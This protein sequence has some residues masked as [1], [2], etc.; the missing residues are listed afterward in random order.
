MPNDYCGL[1]EVELAEVRERHRHFVPVRVDDRTT[2][3][4]APSRNVEEARKR[5]IKEVKY[6]RTKHLQDE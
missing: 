1:S 6:W 2:I 3:F 5:F 4:I